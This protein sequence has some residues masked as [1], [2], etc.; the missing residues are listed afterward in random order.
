MA[1][2]KRTRWRVFVALIAP[3]LALQTLTGA[4]APEG[5]EP[6]V[7]QLEHIGPSELFLKVPEGVEGDFAVAQEAPAI[8]FAILPGQR[9]TKDLWSAWGD[10]LYAS[11]GKFYATIGDHAAWGTTY[12]YQVDPDAGTVRLVIDVNK[13]LGLRR[14]DY[15]AGKIHAPIIDRGDGWLY[16]VNY[17]GTAPGAES[18]YKGDWFFRYEMAT[19]KVEQLGVLVP[20]CGVA[21]LRYHPPSDTLYGLAEGFGLEV[22]PRNKFFAYDLGRRGLVYYGGPEPGMTRAL[23]VAANGRAYYGGTDK[24]LKRYDPKAKTV[25]SLDQQIPGDGNL[26]A[27]SRPAADGVIYAISADGVLFAFDPETERITWSAR[28]FTENSHYI[29]T[30]RL[31]PTERYLYYVPDAHG[32]AWKV[33][34]PLIQFDLDAQKP[35]GLAFF[36]EFFVQNRAYNLGGTYGIALSPDGGQLLI[37]WNGAPVGDRQQGF[38]LCSA[39]IVHI[40]Q[41]E[42]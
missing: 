14:E 15:A 7:A 8:D 9:E 12:V 35:K 26:R 4:R 13:A 24:M 33:G 11:D 19:G 34:A 20:G 29:T 42:R 10:S 22:A 17:P 41:S 27:V 25:A 16:F 32:G 38:G 18:S 5:G 23:M 2:S 6:T 31:D 40:P 30:C 21:A 37:C 3:L 39:M 28:A 1:V 36:N